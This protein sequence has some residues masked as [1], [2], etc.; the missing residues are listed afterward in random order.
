MT[1]RVEDLLE[2]VL[3]DRETI[4]S[5]EMNLDDAVV[6]TY[7]GAV[8]VSGYYWNGPGRPAYFA[9]IYETVFDSEVGPE[10]DLELVTTSPVFFEDNGHAIAWAINVITEEE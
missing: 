3:R 7:D 2:E 1:I 9:A 4:E 6:L 8:I 10:T 5:L